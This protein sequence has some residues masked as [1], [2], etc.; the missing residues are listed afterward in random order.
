MRNC[1]LV[2]SSFLALTAAGFVLLCSGLLALAFTLKRTRW[3]RSRPRQSR[4][5][6][7]DL[8]G[9]LAPQSCSNFRASGEMSNF[10]QESVL[11]VHHWTNNLFSFTRIRRSASVAA[12]AASRNSPMAK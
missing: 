9:K 8:F 7:P 5:V 1:D 10:N 4:S 6:E 12:A 2:S 11:S 3:L